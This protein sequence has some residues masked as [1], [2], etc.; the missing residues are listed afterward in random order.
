MKVR[1]IT[2]TA[3]FRAKDKKFCIMFNANTEFLTHYLSVAIRKFKIETNGFNLVGIALTPDL[4]VPTVEFEEYCQNVIVSLPFSDENK[5]DYLKMS[6]DVD[7]FEFY[8]QNIL[9]GY[10]LACKYGDLQVDKMERIIDVFR[11]ND[12]RFEWTFAKKRL[13]D[14]NLY[15]YLNCYFRYNEFE[16][17]LEAY[18]MKRTKFIAEGTMIKTYPSSIC[19][20]SV[21]CKTKVIDGKLI[22]LGYHDRP[23]LEVD[24]E[25]LSQGEFNVKLLQDRYLIEKKILDG[26]TWPNEEWQESE[27]VSDEPNMGNR[28]TN[29][30]EIESHVSNVLKK[31][32][33]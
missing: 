4:D 25:K 30:E 2:H 28:I 26:L 9:Y 19:Y 13:K 32:I 15:I 8:I 17:K 20:D 27:K 10:R 23:S 18:N 14:Y 29:R 1:Y 7:R 33:V 22:V 21:F 3:N 24:L 16:L 11:Q 5:E 31:I 6:K 12:Y